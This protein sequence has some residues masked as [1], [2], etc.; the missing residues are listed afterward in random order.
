MSAENEGPRWEPGDD[1]PS[2]ANFAVGLWAAGFTWSEIALE[3]NY[4]SPAKARDAVEKAVAATADDETKSS[5]RRK[6]HRRYERL[7]RAVWAKAIDTGSD[8][9]IAAVRAAADLMSRQAKLFGLDAPTE[10]GIV[11]PTALELERFVSEHTE[12]LRIDLPQEPDTIIIGELAEGGSGGDRSA[13]DGD[14]GEAR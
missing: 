3:L 6:M 12:H 14:R 4:S 1:A 5:M 11:T 10:I 8:E 9:Q 7:L 13:Q 2:K